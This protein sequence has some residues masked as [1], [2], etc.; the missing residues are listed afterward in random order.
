MVARVVSETWLGEDGKPKP[1]RPP[2]QFDGPRPW[3]FDP[4]LGAYYQVRI[5]RALKGSPTPKLKIWSQN[6]TARF[7]LKPGEKHVMF[8]SDE[9]FDPPIGHALTIDI[10][11]NSKPLTRARRLLASLPRLSRP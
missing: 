2:F 10:C 9:T 8:V 4:Y 7:W 6:S 11:G 5:L 1:L 3:G